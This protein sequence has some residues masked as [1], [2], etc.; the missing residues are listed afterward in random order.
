MWYEINIIVTV[1]ASILIGIGIQLCISI[2][3]KNHVVWCLQNYPEGLAYFQRK[4]N[5]VRVFKITFSIFLSCTCF[6]NH[7]LGLREEQSKQQ[8]KN[9]SEIFLIYHQHYSTRIKKE[10]TNFVNILYLCCFQR[11]TLNKGVCVLFK[12]SPEFLVDLEGCIARKPLL[13]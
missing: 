5:L 3:H 2:I 8:F 12:R 10:Y 11:N 7:V 6:T 1:Q 4:P 9:K 13:K